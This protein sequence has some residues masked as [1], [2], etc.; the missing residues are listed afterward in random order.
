M[1]NNIADQ[2]MTSD[3]CI[4]INAYMHILCMG[5]DINDLVN[6]TYVDSL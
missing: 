6:T 5:C 3:A 1:S 4:Y 2:Y